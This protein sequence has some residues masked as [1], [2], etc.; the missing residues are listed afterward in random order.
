MADVSLTVNGAHIIHG[1][2]HGDGRKYSDVSDGVGVG[3]DPLVVLGDC[4]AASAPAGANTEYEHG[5]GAGN[6][7]T[8]AGAGNRSLHFSG[9]WRVN[10]VWSGDNADWDSVPIFGGHD[11]IGL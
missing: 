1:C 5:D 8:E 7:Y 3:G 10:V 9:W 2:G 6:C 4:A 11:L